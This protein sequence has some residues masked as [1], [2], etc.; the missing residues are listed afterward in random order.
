MSPSRAPPW[1][2]PVSHC[3]ATPLSRE[4]IFQYAVTQ[5]DPAWPN[6]FGLEAKLANNDLWL[7]NHLRQCRPCARLYTAYQDFLGSPEIVQER[8]AQ[9]EQRLR[10]HEPGD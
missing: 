10:A 6:R 9:I 2:N 5:L 7:P 1:P 3:H 8:A 4:D